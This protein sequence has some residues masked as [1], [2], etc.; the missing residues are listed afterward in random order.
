MPRKVFDLA[1]NRFLE[2]SARQYQKGMETY[3][4]PLAPFN[5]RNSVTDAWEELIDLANYLAQIEMEFNNIAIYLYMFSQIEGFGSLIP[6]DIMKRLKYVV[7]DETVETLK[8]KMGIMGVNDATE[9]DHP[10]IN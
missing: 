4:K 7:G 1:T 3:G 2:V 9:S 10:K 6:A 8:K 5:G